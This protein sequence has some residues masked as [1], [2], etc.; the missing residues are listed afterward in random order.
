MVANEETNGTNGTT[1][2]EPIKIPVWANVNVYLKRQKEATG[3]VVDA[4]CWSTLDMVNCP[5]P[6]VEKVKLNH[7]TGIREATG[8]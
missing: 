2:H 6:K 8:H 4:E 5:L 7:Y 3:E 1:E